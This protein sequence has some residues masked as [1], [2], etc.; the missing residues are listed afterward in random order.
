MSC[1]EPLNA[2]GQ[3]SKIRAHVHADFTTRPD[4]GSS[5]PRDENAKICYGGGW[6]AG[7]DVGGVRHVV[8][9][10]RND[11]VAVREIFLGRQRVGL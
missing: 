1:F 8:D 2:R 3:V 7:C 4:N 6:L 10:G 5:A 9:G 11:V